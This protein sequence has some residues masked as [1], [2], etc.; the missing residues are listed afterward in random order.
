MSRQA[1]SNVADGV[2]GNFLF[3]P[4]PHCVGKDEHNNTGASR[5]HA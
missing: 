3:S 2:R 1:N 5:V 4:P